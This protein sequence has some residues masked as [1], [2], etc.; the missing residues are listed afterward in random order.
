[1]LI[2][3]S[4]LLMSYRQSTRG[5][6]SYSTRG[7]MSSSFSK[8]VET[9]KEYIVDITDVGRTGDGIARIQGFVIS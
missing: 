3:L 5:Y 9:G 2:H 8:P 7:T 4:E 6:S 1:M